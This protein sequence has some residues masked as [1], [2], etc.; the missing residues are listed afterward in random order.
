MSKK[1]RLKGQSLKGRLTGLSPPIVGL[2]WVAPVDEQDKA[3]RL[4]IFLEDRRVLFNPFD[5]EAWS[6]VTRSI[7]DIRQRLTNDLEDIP[8]DSPLGQCIVAML[9]A[10][11]KFLDKTRDNRSRHAGSGPRFMTCLGELRAIFGVYAAQIAYAYD[12]EIGGELSTIIP[13]D[14]DED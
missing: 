4:L 12:L 8:G 3:K 9:A 14:P 2:N 1:L 10:C 13:P 7:L 5:M 6:D 11:R